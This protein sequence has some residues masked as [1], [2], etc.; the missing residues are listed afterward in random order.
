MNHL[1]YH[2]SLE[3]MIISIKYLLYCIAQVEGEMNNLKIVLRLGSCQRYFH[4]IK[5]PFRDKVNKLR[6]FGA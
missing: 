3:I 2:C 6:I 1:S 5:S 4:I